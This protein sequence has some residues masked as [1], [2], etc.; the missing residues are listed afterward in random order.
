MNN[1][2]VYWILVLAVMMIFGV[3]HYFYDKKIEKD[4]KENDK[5]CKRG[6]NLLKHRGQKNV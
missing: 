1:Q 2:D 3:A 6:E 5:A 4:I